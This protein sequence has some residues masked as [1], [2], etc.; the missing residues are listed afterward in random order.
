[1]ET[2]LT[3]LLCN[4]RGKYA[5]LIAAH[6][7]VCFAN[8]PFLHHCWASGFLAVDQPKGVVFSQSDWPFRHEQFDVVMLENVLIERSSLMDIIRNT[9]NVLHGGGFLIVYHHDN[10][11]ALSASALQSTVV[12]FGLEKIHEV[13][14]VKNRHK[15]VFKRVL[16]WLLPSFCHLDYIAIYQKPYGAQPLS[17]ASQV[18]VLARQKAY[19]SSQCRSH[20]WSHDL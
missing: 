17:S 20:N 18:E 14:N 11:D 4:H 19:R 2:I 13:Y 16:E 15:N 5:L 12:H 9:V 6:E 1:M 10:S 7:N 3:K 8:A